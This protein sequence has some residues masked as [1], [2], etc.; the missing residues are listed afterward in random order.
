MRL[1]VSAL[2]L[3]P[4]LSCATAAPSATP[5]S[6]SS[7]RH[8][9]STLSFHWPVPSTATVIEAVE[10]GPQ[11]AKLRYTLKLL[12]DGERLRLQLRE[13][14]FIEMNHDPVDTDAERAQMR[15][16]LD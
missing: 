8:T 6:T 14:E 9:A 13:M 2:A 5:P 12:Q 11:A 4:L 1:L 3:V 10:K 7:G 15:Q 16:V